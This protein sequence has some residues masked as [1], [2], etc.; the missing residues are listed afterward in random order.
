MS[1]EA[2]HAGTPISFRQ[3]MGKAGVFSFAVCWFDVS[4]G[5]KAI[6]FDI[7]TSD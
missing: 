3:E 1:N 7:I 5:N 4:Q 6:Y 2:Y